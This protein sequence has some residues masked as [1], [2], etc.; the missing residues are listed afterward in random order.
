MRWTNSKDKMAIVTGGASGIGRE[1]CKELSRK[2]TMVVAVD[3]GEEGAQ[4]VVSAITAAGGRARATYLDESEEPDVEKLINKT[5][6]EDWQ[7]DYM[8]YNAGI[9][10][11]GEVGDMAVEQGRLVV[12]TTL[13]GVIYGTTAAYSLMVR[14]GFRHIINTAPVAGLIG[15]PG[16]IRYAASK[17]AVVSL[18]RSLRGE[19][20][21]LG[22]KVSVVCPGYVNTS[23]WDNGTL[24]KAV[25]E[26]FVTQ[27]PFK[28]KNPNKAALAI[29]RGIAGN[30]AIMMFPLHARLLWWVYRFLPLILT[31]LG[32]SMV[33]NFR[34]IRRGP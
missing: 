4:E 20:A 22:V 30:Q 17:Y 10:V 6:P 33:K 26:D 14:Q 21:G 3:V 34:R 7:L 9:V 1:L 15:Y 19:A 24:L 31:P 12:D 8:F 27:I 18:S 29:L 5:A 16:D 28:M 25:K 23:I 13:Q 2:G 32:R 11:V